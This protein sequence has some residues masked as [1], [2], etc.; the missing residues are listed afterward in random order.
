MEFGYQIGLTERPLIKVKYTEDEYVVGE[1]HCEF[2]AGNDGLAK[3]FADRLFYRLDLD[4][5]TDLRTSDGR[6]VCM[7]EGLADRASA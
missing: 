3:A 4:G 1:F 6:L 2:T 5:Q 7:I